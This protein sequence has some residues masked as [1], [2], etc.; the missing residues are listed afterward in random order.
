MRYQS[1]Q[2]NVQLNFH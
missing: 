2:E 1:L